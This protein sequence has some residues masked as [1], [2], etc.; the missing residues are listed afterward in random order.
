ME[1]LGWIRSFSQM[2]S[3][4]K[5][6]DQLI[7]CFYEPYQN[8]TI[9]TDLLYSILDAA[10]D[11]ELKVRS[12]IAPV[13]EFL[14]QSGLIHPEKFCFVS[15][16]AISK[17]SDPDMSIKSAF[18]R[19]ISIAVPV[20]LYIHGITDRGYLCKLWPTTRAYMYY[21][22]WKQALCLKQMPQKLHSQQLVSVLNYISQRWKVPH[23]S[24]IRQLVFSCRGRKD[25]ISNQEEIIG[26]HASS[27]YFEDAKTDELLLQK[28]CQVNSLA[29]IWWSVNEAARYCI[30]L[31][32][33]TNLGGPAQTFAALERMLLDM[34]NILKLDFEQSEGQYLG[35]SNFHM[36][37]IRLLL[38]F[39]EALKKNAYNAYEGSAVLPHATRQ[40]SLFFRANKKVCE[41]W[42]SRICE[43][44]LNAGFALNCHDATFY[45]CSS[46]LQELQ[47][48][49]ASP[50]KDKTHGL[51]ENFKNQ[52]YIFTGDILK[53]LQRASLALC[54]GREPEALVGLQKWVG[55]MF[56]PFFVDG[57]PYI[58]S[59]ND[60]DMHFS[61]MTGLVYQ[62]KGQY[63]KAAAH[64]SHLLQSEEALGSIGSDGI[65]FI[66]ARVI[67]CYTSLS[68][69]KSLENWLSELQALRSMHAGKPYSGALTAAGN[70]MNA[71]HALARFDEGDIQA[72][73]G[74]L[75]LTPKSSCQLTLDPKLAFERSEQM[76][77]LS[78]LQ[79]EGSTNKVH[80]DLDK[81]KV[82]LDE[83]LSCI[84]L[85]GLT[86]A[87]P[88]AVQLHCI[89]AMEEWKSSGQQLP[90]IL[91]SF[92]QS[93]H[94]PISRVR[95]DSNLWMKIFRVYCTIMPASYATNLLG[96][97][98]LSLARKQSNFMLAGRLRKYLHEHPL[99]QHKHAEFL[100]VN[101]QYEEI[102]LK[103]A[104]GDTDEAL[105]DL[106]SF[107]CTDFQSR[108]TSCFSNI[109]TTKAKAC[110]K[111]ASWMSRKSSNIDLRSFISK[112]HEDL[113]LLSRA[114]GTLICSRE[115]FSSSSS[116]QTS[117]TK[118]NAVLEEIIGT[119]TK[120]SCKL[121]P[122][123]GKAWLSYAAWCFTQA[124]NSFSGDV[125][126]LQSCSLSSVLSEEISHVRCQLT[127]DEKSNITSI[128]TS[129]YHSRNHVAV[130]RDQESGH[131]DS[132]SYPECQEFLNSLVHDT[133]LIME[134][135]AGTPGFE[136]FDG[137]CP[138]VILFSEL[139]SHFF[140]KVAGMDKSDTTSYIHDLIEIWWLLRKRRVSLFGYAAHG[141][142]QFLS[143]SSSGLKES[144]CTNFHPGHTIDK[145]S[146]CILRAMLYILVILLNFGVE[147]EETLN[148][149]FAT[150]PPLSW[151][152]II[153][154]LFARV[155]SHPQ[156]AVRKH[157]EGL[158]MILAKL[159]PCSIVY[160][161]LVNLNAYEGQSVVEL[162]NI[163]TY[164]SN[165]HPKLI[166]D[167]LLVI[168]ELGGITI[169]WEEQ[170]LSTLQDLRTDV[171][172]RINMLKEEASRIADNST[173]CH[174]EKNKINA[175]K[176]SAMM[177]PI[178]VALER[179]LASTSREAETLHE[180]W[181]QKEYGKQLKSAILSFKTAPSSASALDNVWQVFDAI[182]AS[183]AVYQR[184][185][186]FY[187]GEV[188]PKLALLSSSNVP[189]PGLEREISLLDVCEST[190]AVQ[191]IITISSFNEQIEILSTKTRP[192]KLALLGSDGEKYTYLLKG[193]EDLR[194]DARIM[195]LLQAI[196]GFFI[197]YS[198]SLS[199]SIGVRH[200]SVTP[201]SGQAGLIQWV[202]NVIS[203]YSVYKSWQYRSQLT[204]CSGSGAI[205]FSNSVPQVPRPSDMFYGKII[206][207]LK[208]KG[209]RRVI[210][211]RDWPH[212]VKKKVLLDL[213]QE[214]P[215]DLLWQEMWCSSEGFKT[216][217]SKIRRFSGGVA[218][219]SIIG[220]VLGLGDRHLDN[221]LMNF[222]TGEVVHIDYNVCFDK[223]R[224]LK[225]PE[226]VPFRLTQTIVA[227]LGL[228]GTEGIFRIN[229][230]TVINILRKNKD[231]VL[232][233]LEVFIWDPLVEWTRDDMHDEATVGGEEKKGMELA[234]SL[235]LFA[236]R[237]QEI[238]IPLQ[239]HR[240]LL[241][242]TL[243][244]A[245]CALKRFLD[246]LIR[247]ESL[248]VVFHHTD[249][250]RSSL[251]QHETTAKSFAAE[252]TAITEKSRAYFEAQT[253][254]FTHAK[255]L[256]TEKAQEAAAWME[257][258]GRVL[259]ALRSGSF[260][261]S[262]ACI[263]LH[264]MEE[265]LSLKSSVLVSGV[266][267]TVVPEP[268]QAQ[269]YD[270]DREMSSIIAE[271]DNGLSSG[272]EALH[273]YALALQ[274]LPFNYVTS[275]PVN[276]WAQI[277]QHTVNNLS[278][279]VLSLA[280]RQSADIMT[281][282]Q[283]TVA[284]SIQ[285]RHHD[286]FVN[287]ERFTMEIEMVD[288]QCSEQMNSIGLDTEEKSKERLLSVFFEHM[289]PA[290]YGSREDDFHLKHLGTKLHDGSSDLKLLNDPDEKKG[291]A[292]YILHIAISDL[293][294]DV[295][296]NLI[297]ISK[298]S[299]GKSSWKTDDSLPNNSDIV[300]AELEDQIEKCVLLAGFVT[301][302]QE[303]IGI[304]SFSI[305]NTKPTS[306]HCWASVFQA[307]LH[308]IKQLIEKLTCYVLPE[309]IQ[310]VVS[311]SAEVM[312]AFGSLSRVRGSIHEAL[313]KIAEV[314]KERASLL[315]LEQNY[316]I[317][318]G[319][320]TEQQ[321]SLEEASV[322]GRDHLSWE[323]TE[324]LAT[325]IDAC[326]AQL[327][328]LHLL[329]N[330]KDT[331]I[332]SL[333][334]MEADIS[335]S[336]SSLEGYFSS[337]IGIEED[338]ESHTKGSKSLLFALV[339]PFTKLES[340][341]QM[342]SSHASAGFNSTGS[343]CTLPH[344]MSGFP[345][346]DSIWRFPYLLKKHSFFIWK[347][348]VVDSILDSWMHEI[349]SSVDHNIR[350]DQLCNAL[351]KK[352]GAHLQEYIG[353]YLKERVAPA[354]LAHLDRENKKLHQKIEEMDLVSEN[355]NDYSEAVR[356]FRL[357]LEEYC[358][359]HETAK[360]ARSAVYIMKRHVN[361]LTEALHKTA[362]EIIQ[363]E[364]MHEQ[365]LPQLL[366]SKVFLQNTSIDNKLLN[367]SRGNL[368]GKVQSSISSVARSL[369]SLQALEKTSIAAEG[370]LERAMLWACAGSNSVG[371][372]SS[373]T[374]CSRIP[375]E[376]HNHLSRR[377]KLLWTAQ[378]H[379]SDVIKI[380]TYVIEFEASRDGL[381]WVHR[382]KFSE[383][384][385]DSRTWQS[386]LT[387]L[388]RLDSAHHSFARAE[389]EWLLSQNK[390]EAASKGLISATNEFFIASV[391]AKSASA[392]LQDNLMDMRKCGFEAC[393]ALSSFISVSEGHTALTSEGGSMLE[394]VLAITEGLHDIYG[395]AKEASFVHC[396]LVTDLAKA[397]VILQPLEASLSSGM[398][399]MND[400]K[401]KECTTD[402][403]S[404][405]GQALYQSHCFGLQ[406]AV[407]SLASLVPSITSC[408]N[409]LFSMLTK[410]ARDASIHSGNL[411]K[412]LEGLGE[413]QVMRSQ[414]ISLSRPGF[415]N[416]LYANEKIFCK[417]DEGV[418]DNSTSIHEF[419]FDDEGWIS[420][421]DCSYT[422]SKDF[423]MASNDA[424]ESNDCDIKNCSK[425]KL[426]DEKFKSGS[427]DNEFN[428]S[429][430]ASTAFYISRMKS[431]LG[432]DSP[433]SDIREG[434]FDGIKP[435]DSSTEH[436]IL[437][438]SKGDEE[439]HDDSTSS[440]PLRWSN[441]G[442]KNA[443][444]VSILGQV[445]LKI[446][447]RDIDNERVMQAS[448]QV[449]HLIMEATSID[450]LCSMSLD[451]RGEDLAVTG[452]RNSVNLWAPELVTMEGIADFGDDAFRPPKLSA[453]GEQIVKF[454]LGT[455]LDVTRYVSRVCEVKTLSADD[456]E[457][458]RMEI[459][460]TVHT[461][462]I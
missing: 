117:D 405:H 188:A 237:F 270:L 76:L 290:W 215:R 311:S 397:K 69:W 272:I 185:S 266:P 46:R 435:V 125:P 50:F 213:M 55:T 22:N 141:Y 372:F 378:Q 307:I 366:K 66:I 227:A 120:Q 313:E 95:Q 283:G 234:V 310:S 411:H 460:V 57:T 408:A 16:V 78:M 284:D 90:S 87:A 410:L 404:I 85:D 73:W 176:Y 344:L 44:M 264:S 420:S 265:A 132:T 364:W 24:W 32:L 382:E 375:S 374:N 214:T 101:L 441:R 184:K 402:I 1:A 160:P 351:K 164:L 218:A 387:A 342:L 151:Q 392:D 202:D 47:K 64:F 171:V 457:Y 353:K 243:P 350:F 137:E 179:R 99:S 205:N 168:N 461:F 211:R 51:L 381:N 74:Y 67:E 3:T 352:L 442:K 403:L 268:T 174:T 285:K 354:F 19:L 422:S 191:G 412:A 216:F 398:E 396:A 301:E 190:S 156:Q 244:A 13:L 122:K 257:G 193:R 139:Q 327:D 172:R 325:Q 232:M 170:W 206:P 370:K 323:E 77:L 332:T 319:L 194:L 70:E 80:A 320:I 274:I 429:G 195:Q 21:M 45:Y 96:Q 278:T 315:E 177:S 423:S 251:L 220:H 365:T 414:E 377:R 86:E 221:I 443:Y 287:L 409:E 56:P 26:D 10:F 400:A 197:S 5:E 224:R 455:L 373:A 253:N 345:L 15:E 360:A 337:L 318:V 105:I 133:T 201:I 97:R 293:Y 291:R 6:D 394:E 152:E 149:G 380:C 376:F 37:P 371:S 445:E 71:I 61:W 240:D 303:F 158:L 280:M 104:A 452:V 347:I 39:V 130:K 362:L 428:A 239:E 286:L 129:I 165:L 259:D 41:E 238:R 406:E 110:L 142:F 236:S 450:N 163:K 93:L 367:I 444:A 143:Y 91:D 260:P 384:T 308:A 63:E 102:L 81:A 98:M 31:R 155:S 124:K 161:L 343:S 100:A 358:N 186:I 369:E 438:P 212:E 395:L 49:P 296:E 145:S 458:R 36:L 84:P 246:V 4:I 430:P 446:D 123:L 245:E 459:Y 390:M 192:K 48:L 65:Q 335:N 75:D 126:V 183:L 148:H 59:V 94:S 312:E 30:N 439:N 255:S 83:A 189:M 330:E 79:K 427:S 7:S 53:V 162:Q 431:V 34:P 281:K 118:W 368:M 114:N 341:D 18:V 14:L 448:Q 363:L 226:I 294:K 322:R 456:L 295:K 112:I 138:S 247:Y 150:V 462:G 157:I 175:A 346:F 329:W 127:D 275:S 413:S 134:A 62:A 271:L 119:S 204:Q 198:D 449:D 210:S 208:E 106:W 393:L 254:E 317:K 426:S 222:I 128:V 20:S 437:S 386:Y 355:I 324:E 336:L 292:L 173:L 267:L 314:E 38:D 361:E 258:H 40:S 416:G 248:S 306:E 28:T 357:M 144:N 115:I 309:I 250:E 262:Q 154:Q 88:L 187:L 113:T 207:A 159:S 82:M 359:A 389:Q 196:N 23:S 42:F 242:S 326:R 111:L 333:A 432:T 289:Q 273:E 233:L 43:P 200:Y 321:R 146:S 108:T 304:T 109:S 331:R 235:S 300:S 178:V 153:P 230:E 116:S 249:K 11:R 58:P 302:I 219:M 424:E 334:R 388:R 433:A 103:N 229:C 356:R 454:L 298:C 383:Q 415:S 52:N 33:R 279:E 25:G 217:H 316:F 305:D 169:L 9:D 297:S 182:A 256:A 199:Q 434:T 180:Q 453:M 385:G 276:N 140:R 209:I 436:Y 407:H 17:L 391:K 54:K 121:C 228:T 241:V 166:Q 401:L 348:G 225:I 68:D 107:V 417:T 135:A 418:L 231:I 35:S 340:V 277:L 136:S 328:I 147:L 451:I 299:S 338:G 12:H 419:Q 8:I 282:D 349:A 447:G 339:K 92:S 60:N 2:V 263:A 89:L 399:T 167:V 269:C 425:E 252:I 261:S 440:N 421:P 131:F 27:D 223:G 29:A 72:A 181:F 288:K 203:I 379:A